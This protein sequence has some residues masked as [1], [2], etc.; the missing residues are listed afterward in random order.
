MPKLRREELENWKPEVEIASVF[1]TD[2][3]K[4]T[5]IVIDLKT[6]KM[7]YVVTNNSSDICHVQN[8]DEAIDVYNVF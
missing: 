5:K 2:T 1:G 4:S 7:E 3:Y 6:D 8:L